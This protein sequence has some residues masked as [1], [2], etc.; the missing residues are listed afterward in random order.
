MRASAVNIV[1]NRGY[2]LLS[3]SICKLLARSKGATNKEGEKG[4]RERKVL[5]GDWEADIHN[6]EKR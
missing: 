2:H 3:L 4:K 6:L 1:F 5:G